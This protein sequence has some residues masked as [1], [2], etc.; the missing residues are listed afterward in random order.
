MKRSSLLRCL[1]G[2]LF[3]F[4]ISFSTVGQL[5]TGIDISDSP[6]DYAAWCCICSVILAAI[7]YFRY[8]WCAVLILS[9]GG[10]Y[11]L[12]KNTRIVDQ[13]STLAYKLTS[14][15]NKVYGTAIIG[16][17]KIYSFDALLLFIAFLTA[18][19]VC[20]T[21]CRRKRLYP[22]LI[23]AL[24]P[25]ALL[26]PVKLT[27]PDTVYMYIGMVSIAVLLL[28][29]HVR[30][31]DPKRFLSL[32]LRSL[33]AAGAALALLISQFPRDDYTYLDGQLQERVE[34]LFDGAG[35]T[36]GGI[37]S[38]SSTGVTAAK[39]ID[40]RLLGPKNDRKYDVM[41]VSST[42]SGI[43]YLRGRDYDIYNGTAWVSSEGRREKTLK[44]RGVRGTVTITT[45]SK[46][47]YLY[48]PYFPNDSVSITNGYTENEF[49]EKEYTFTVCEYPIG[50][51]YEVTASYTELPSVT[52]AW[53]TTLV[54]GI[55]ANIRTSPA[56]R[57]AAIAEAIG[58]YVKTSAEY[59]LNPAPMGYTNDDFAKWFLFESETGYCA[60]F[61]SAATVLLRAAN[62]PA[63]YVEGYYVQCADEELVT[64]N[65]QRAHA[66]V[67]YY[68]AGSSTWHILEATPAEALDWNYVYEDVPVDTFTPVTEDTAPP[69]DTNEPPVTD[70]PA[71]TENTDGITD[72][73]DTGNA[74]NNA[75]KDDTPSELPRPAK[76]LFWIAFALILIPLQAYIRICIKACYWD[77]GKPNEM[78]LCRWRQCETA[79]KATRTPLPDKLEDI[80]L[81]AR[82]SQHTVSPEELAAFD[83]FRK[84]VLASINKMPWYKKAIMRCVFAIG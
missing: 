46:E 15:Y 77:K 84:R 20:F 17:S 75:P 76:A 26:L 21:V 45:E 28:T 65:N 81:K 49:N 38:G 58:E 67:E 54:S 3:A 35:Y 53:A 70:V 48:I 33:A 64:V 1:I 4:L 74:G 78:A 43:V 56:Q 11:W 82:F 24:L 10:G 27:Q 6:A 32:A 42:F 29:E 83:N 23:A 37:I 44:G 50:Y 12:Y 66:W 72:V 41:T 16:K 79:A 57:T 63:R 19:A 9:A 73:P 31:K 5:I 39:A 30:I 14:G 69:E 25:F 60:H 47:K 52:R 80:A 13:L 61:A 59:G 51:P 34:D 7:F 55:T 40:L 68:D 71:D 18:A 22:A 62:I 36:F 2:A 8:G